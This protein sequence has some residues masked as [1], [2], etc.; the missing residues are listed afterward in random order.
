MASGFVT[1]ARSALT[2][3]PARPLSGTPQAALRCASLH[4]RWSS[5][6]GGTVGEDGRFDA[7]ATLMQILRV[8]A[9]RPE[10]RPEEYYEK[11]E[12]F[13]WGV[14]WGLDN[15]FVVPSAPLWWQAPHPAAAPWQLAR[16]GLGPNPAAAA[17]AA[18]QQ[19][20]QAA[21][22]CRRFIDCEVDPDGLVPMEERMCSVR[23]N[24]I[25]LLPTP[26]CEAELSYW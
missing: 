20:R 23:R 11:D 1:A 9:Q 25:T 15:C 24:P 6:F 3:L 14:L 22:P 16:P 13:R 5:V 18:L 26:P 17:R 4:L 21:R 7:F 8:K 19:H 12:A 10:L 2:P